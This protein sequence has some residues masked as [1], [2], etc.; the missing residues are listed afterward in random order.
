MRFWIE[1]NGNQYYLH[2]SKPTTPGDGVD[3]MGGDGYFHEEAN[4]LEWVG[5]LPTR[6]GLLFEY[7][8]TSNPVLVQKYE[9]ACPR[10]GRSTKENKDE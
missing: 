10:C 6:D 9:P 4:L 5:E 2:L 8:L 3:W 1:K 7:A